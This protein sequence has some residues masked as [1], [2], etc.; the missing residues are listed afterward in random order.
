MPD[1][2]RWVQAMDYARG[3]MIEKIDRSP[4]GLPVIKV[5]TR[6]P[7]QS[8]EVILKGTAEVSLPA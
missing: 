8:G 6:M 1:D 2:R 3:E 5:A 7:T 4:Y